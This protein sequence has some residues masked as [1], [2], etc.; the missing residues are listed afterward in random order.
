[1]SLHDTSPRDNFRAKRIKPF[2]SD[3]V[4]KDLRMAHGTTQFI[5]DS[6]GSATGIG[7][8]MK[9]GKME[10]VNTNGD[11]IARLGFRDTDGDGAVDT[12]KPGDTL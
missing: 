5:Y 3:G 7:V 8:R 11:V 2:Y 10:V 12:A 6:D 9:S 1:M 4:P